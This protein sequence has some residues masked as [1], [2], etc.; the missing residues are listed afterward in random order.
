MLLHED[1]ELFR[2]V[3]ISTSEELGIVVPII[4]KDYYVT[5]ILRQ[6]TKRKPECVF[7]GGTSLSKCHHVIDRFS[8][9]ID[10]TFSDKLTQGMRKKLKNDIICGISNELGMPILNFENTRSRRDYNCYTFSYDPIDDFPNK[11]MLFQGVKMEVSLGS[12]S[13]PEWISGFDIP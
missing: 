7:K 1:K 8:E 9:D 12:T 10:I 5:M 4:E 6:L 2:E 13:F 3:I 11:D